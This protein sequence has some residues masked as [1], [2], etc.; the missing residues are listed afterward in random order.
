MRTQRGARLVVIRYSGEAVGSVSWIL[1][2]EQREWTALT[3]A[4]VCQVRD[5]GIS[6][7]IS[8]RS[9]KT[10]NVLS[11]TVKCDLHAREDTDTTD[12]TGTAAIAEKKS[13]LLVF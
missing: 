9:K 10:R 2:R 1:I 6:Q 4:G 8:V 5:L 12:G 11:T 7:G 3:A 13:L